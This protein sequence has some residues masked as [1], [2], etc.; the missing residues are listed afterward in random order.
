MAAATDAR[1]HERYQRGGEHV[2]IG[3]DA[4]RSD[5]VPE[6]QV[7]SALRG[8]LVTVKSA[9]DRMPA[10]LRG[11]DLVYWYGRALKAEGRPAEAQT[12]FCGLRRS[13]TFTASWPRGSRNSDRAAARP[14]VD[15]G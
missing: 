11:A 2:G 7:R 6:W 15:R 3:A 13:S 10:T 12:T 4:V 8:R 1:R 9:I 14:G 5:E